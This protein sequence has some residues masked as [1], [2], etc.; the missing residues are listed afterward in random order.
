ME[1]SVIPELHEQMLEILDAS[2]RYQQPQISV[3]R[4]GVAVRVAGQYQLLCCDEEGKMLPD[5]VKFEQRTPLASAEDNRVMLWPGA[6]CEDGASLE[7]M[8]SVAA[9]T[10]L[11]SPVGMAVGLEIGQ[12]KQP[13]PD[14]PS[15]ILKRIAEEDLWTLAKRYGSTVDAIRNANQL[16]ED[17]ESGMMLLIPVC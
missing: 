8:L 9:F 4:E 16:M 3:D 15:V 1:I 6:W 17:A 13:D 12:E 5:T 7:G 10:F 14:R 2:A 11:A